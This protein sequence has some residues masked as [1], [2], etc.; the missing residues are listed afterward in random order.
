M[1]NQLVQV[2]SN[3]EFGTIRTLFIDGEIYFVAADICRA[4]DIQNPRDAVSRLSEDEKKLIDLNGVTS[5][6][7]NADGITGAVSGGW[8]KNEINVVNEP[9]LYHLIFQSRKPN[10]VKFQRWVYHEVLPSIRKYG[11]YAVPSIEMLLKQIAKESAK[12]DEELACLAAQMPMLS[13]QM[14]AMMLRKLTDYRKDTSK[15][16]PIFEDFPGEI[17]KWFKGYEGRYQGST[18]GRA[19]SFFYGECKLLIPVINPKGYYNVCLYK[20][21]GTHQNFRLH[22]LIAELFVPNPE[23]KPEVHHKDHNKANNAAWN[24]E[25]VTDE[26]N[27]AYAIEEERFLKGEKNPVSKLTEDIVREIRQSY[28][29]GDLV[30]GAKALARKYNVSDNC[31]FNIVHF[32]TWKHI[33]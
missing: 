2:F 22:R 7:D 29:S 12:N 30:F 16:I 9:G 26:E 24:L 13:L 27:K 21:D 3:E 31:I 11:Y 4:L 17:W 5:S 32:N 10:A 8:I 14:E 23:N 28:K 6:V 1:E 25:W 15:P 33:Q 20:G 18:F 19:R